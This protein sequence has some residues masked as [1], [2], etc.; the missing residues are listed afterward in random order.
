MKKVL[1]A[2]TNKD[3]YEA[4]SKIF[5]ETIFPANEYAI[6]KFT[7][8]LSQVSYPIGYNIPID[9]LLNLNIK[10]LAK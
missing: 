8:S 3:K 2:T 9:G 7:Y 5:K 10:T 1:I 4:V 6:E